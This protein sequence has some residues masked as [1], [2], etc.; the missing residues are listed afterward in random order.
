MHFNPHSISVGTPF[1]FTSCQTDLVDAESEDSILA[2]LIPWHRC[3]KKKNLY[4]CYIFYN[5]QHGGTC[6]FNPSRG[7]KGQHT[8]PVPRSRALTG[9]HQPNVHVF[10]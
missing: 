2:L 4:L 9:K 3:K 7:S 1:S 10:D 5:A 8:H 6:T